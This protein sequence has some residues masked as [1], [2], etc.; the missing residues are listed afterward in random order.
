MSTPDIFKT[1]FNQQ[2]M[3]KGAIGLWGLTIAMNR[4]EECFLNVFVVSTGQ[5]C[6]LSGK[7][8]KSNQSALHLVTV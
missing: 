4:R 5:S 2:A 7:L 6:L 3:V 8:E 1:S